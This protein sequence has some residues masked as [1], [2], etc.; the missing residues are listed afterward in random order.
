MAQSRSSGDRAVFTSPGRR[1]GRPTATSV[2]RH[3]VAA[4]SVGRLQDGHEVIPAVIWQGVGAWVGRARVCPCRCRRWWRLRLALR[5]GAEHVGRQHLGHLMS[6]V[7][8]VDLLPLR[9]RIVV[10]KRRGGKRRGG[11]LPRQSGH[12]PRVAARRSCDRSGRAPDAKQLRSRS[13]CLAGTAHDMQPGSC[14]F[15][16]ESD[17]DRPRA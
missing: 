3:R 13:A 14:R 7:C 15:A 8:V 11:H 2:L 16:D 6:R 10:Q 4:V 9:Q 12:R 17:A 5:L 1:I